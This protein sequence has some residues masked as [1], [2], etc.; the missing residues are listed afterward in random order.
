M[1]EYAE[2]FGWRLPS[3]STIKKIDIDSCD[4]KTILSAL[5]QCAERGMDAVILFLHSH[6]FIKHWSSDAGKRTI[7][8]EDLT[9]FENVVRFIRDDPRLTMSSMED[10]NLGLSNGRISPGAADFIPEVERRIPLVLYT[11]K[12]TRS[13][14]PSMGWDDLLRLM[15]SIIAVSAFILLFVR[16]RQKG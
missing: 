5:S 9:E 14:A 10:F 13:M 6:S 3:M 1:R 11:G 12:R 2:L 16:I 8:Q 15:G 4:E 7:D